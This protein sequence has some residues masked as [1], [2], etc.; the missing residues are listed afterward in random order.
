MRKFYGVIMGFIK[1]AVCFLFVASSAY[2][3]SEDKAAFLVGFAKAD[4]S[5][6][7]A[8][9]DSKVEVHLGG[10][11][12]P[13]IATG[14]YS[15][16]YARVMAVS[17]VNSAAPK[18]VIIA[19]LDLPGISNRH[20]AKIRKLVVSKISI[21]EEN[22]LI[23]ATHSHSGPDMQGLWGGVHA[24]YADYLEAETAQA[25]IAAYNKRENAYLSVSAGTHG[26]GNRRGWGFTDQDVMVM[27]AKSAKTNQR[28]GTVVNFAAH[29]V[30]EDSQS[31]LIGRDF[32]GALVDKM[33]KNLGGISMYVNGIVGD[34]TPNY[35]KNGY[36]GAFEYGESIA[37]EA[38]ASMAT[39][40][41]VDLGEISFTTDS[42]KQ[43]ISN[44]TFSLAY[45]L[46]FLKY[47]A[48]E[49]D[50]LSVQF[51]VRTS[52][53]RFGNQVQV[54]AF[55]GES[56]TRNGLPIKKEMKAPFKMFLGLMGDTL[57]YFV[58]SDE[59]KTKRHD[60]YEESVSMHKHAGDNASKSMFKLIQ[61]DNLLF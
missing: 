32:P 34:V 30:L 29:P 47:D 40:T 33:E 10:Y 2:S 17:E 59:W 36:E 44:R 8:M 15:A 54:A 4:I 22:V 46:G 48:I 49:G 52:L 28:L 12:P 42:W 19:N 23:G 43:P 21:P 41:K 27:D 39:Q 11:L 20:I 35:S 38:I 61:A 14:I 56:L 45:W 24:P 16:I 50:W 9:F 58:P 3:Q 31:R 6:T 18:T 57:G 60:D 37:K 7:Q 13:R 5:P 55:P 25:I 53:I 1:L 26:N 51:A